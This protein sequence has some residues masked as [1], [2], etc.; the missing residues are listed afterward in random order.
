MLE[1]V[2]DERRTEAAP[3][4][5]CACPAMRLGCSWFEDIVKLVKMCGR[6]GSL[7][8][9]KFQKYSLLKFDCFET[10]LQSRVLEAVDER[11]LTSLRPRTCIIATTRDNARQCSPL[12]IIQS[13]IR[14]QRKNLQDKRFRFPGHFLCASMAGQEAA[15]TPDDC[16]RTQY[17]HLEL[18]QAGI[19]VSTNRWSIS[20]VGCLR[21]YRHNYR[22][23]CLNLG[24][25]R[26]LDFTTLSGPAA[27]F[28]QQT[29]QSRMVHYTGI[30]T[31][32]DADALESARSTYSHHGQCSH[33]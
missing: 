25:D 11:R 1:R 12:T 33:R 5:Y 27:V 2:V 17:A 3:F 13:A 30:S 32:H 7:S 23:H 9:S 6:V 28:Y 4:T 19:L 15:K 24:N 10:K 16:Q 31:S 26:M 18:S 22:N 21:C 20:S 8:C 29:W 14:A